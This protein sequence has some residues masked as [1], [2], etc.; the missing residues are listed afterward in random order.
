MKTEDN[1]NR[2]DEE[3][4]QRLAQQIAKIKGFQVLESRAT[5]ENETV[6]TL[7]IDGLEGSEKTPR[8]RMHKINHEWRLAWP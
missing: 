8:M 1:Q 6:L 4:A 3:V 2:T 7:Y 5:A